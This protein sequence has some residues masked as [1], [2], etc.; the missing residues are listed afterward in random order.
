[1]KLFVIILCLIS[2][3][4]ACSSHEPLPTEFTLPQPQTVQP[5]T[6]DSM[7]ANFSAESE[8]SDAVY[9]LGAGDVISVQVWDHPELS[10]AH[11]VGPDG[12]IT[13]PITGSFKVAGFSRE[14]AAQAVT[15]QLMPYYVDLNT[16]VKIDDYAS[17]RVLV[18]GRVSKPGEVRFGMSAPTL[19]EAIAMAGG[20]QPARNLTTSE[21]LPLT[22]C[23]VFRGRNQVVWIELEPLLMGKNLSMNLRLRR[24]DIV[25]IPDINEHLVYV[26]GEVSKPGAYPLTLNM[27]FLEALARA[28]GP[29]ERAA[30]GRI[31]LIRPS[32]E[33]NVK[34]DLDQVLTPDQHQNVALQDGDIIYVPA[35]LAAKINYALQFLTPVSQL[36]SIYS[37]IESV[38][39]DRERRLLSEEADRLDAER[40]SLEQQLDELVGYE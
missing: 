4:V 15:Q 18:L 27:S 28:G 19:L 38:R 35:G 32:A 8:P 17:N 16:T 6:P 36:L 21:S 7:L 23:A 13:L 20:F 29:T 39:A 9:R 33:L 10:S 5:L 30:E 26:L 12:Q 1:M 31:N 37:D 14:Q 25:Y 22:R 34:I 40:K 24:N 2:F 3:L 11:I